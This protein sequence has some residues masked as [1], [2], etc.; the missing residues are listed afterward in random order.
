MHPEGLVHVS[1]DTIAGRDPIK[2]ETEEEMKTSQIVRFV[3]AKISRT[4][5]FGWGRRKWRGRKDCNSSRSRERKSRA[6]GRWKKKGCSRREEIDDGSPSVEVVKTKSNRAL[7]RNAKEKE[8][9]K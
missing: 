3:F 1:I 8:E 9:E 4:I 2:E 7:K 5:V 6:R